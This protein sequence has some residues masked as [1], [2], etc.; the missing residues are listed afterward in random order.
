MST[1]KYKIGQQVLAVHKSHIHKQ[2]NGAKIIVGRVKSYQFVNKKV[3]P[4]V[5]I[6]GNS[7]HEL[8]PEIHTFYTE[9]EEAVEAISEL[10]Q[11]NRK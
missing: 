5:T 11:K 4:I 1:S 9:L 7:R 8:N 10:C 3:Q 2:I 6:V